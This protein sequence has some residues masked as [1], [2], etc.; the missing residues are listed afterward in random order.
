MELLKEKLKSEL[1]SIR[2]HGLHIRHRI[3][4]DTSKL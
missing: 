1:I 4:K 3:R 2:M